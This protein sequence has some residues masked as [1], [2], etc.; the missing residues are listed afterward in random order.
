MKLKRSILIH[1][2]RNKS[3]QEPEGDMYSGDLLYSV[4]RVDNNFWFTRFFRTCI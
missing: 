3:L 4:L 2:D 1:F